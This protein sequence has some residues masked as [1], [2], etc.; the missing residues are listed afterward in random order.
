MDLPKLSLVSLKQVLSHQTAADTAVISSLHEISLRL[1]LST[2]VGLLLG[3]GK[4]IS[5]LQLNSNLLSKD[6]MVVI[7]D[8]RLG[9]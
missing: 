6:F 9:A 8:V 2:V 3:G 4:C 7:G 1:T 5:D